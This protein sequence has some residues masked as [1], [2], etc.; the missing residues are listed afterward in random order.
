V[1][2]H[3]IECVGLGWVVGNIWSEAKVRDGM[4]MVWYHGWLL[5]ASL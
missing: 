4:V 3:A 5:E 1:A 2:R